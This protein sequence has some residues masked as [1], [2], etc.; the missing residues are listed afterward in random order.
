MKLLIETNELVETSISEAL[1]EGG[2]KNVFI[3]GTFMS[4]DK[5]NRNGRYYPKSVLESEVNR[6]LK[7]NVSKSRAYGELNHPKEPQINL[8]RVSHLITELKVMDNGTVHGKA[9]LVD[10]PMGNIARGLIE[11]GANLGVSTRGM[12]SLKEMKEG[13]KE[14]QNDFKLVTAADIVADPS[15]SDAYVDALMENVNWVRDP[16]SGEWIQEQQEAVHKKSR[17]ELEEAKVYL[18]AQYLEK[19]L[20]TTPDYK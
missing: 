11:G 7:E 18:F 3:E 15:A 5:P 12:G 10:T 16:V 17:K 4:Y 19:L 8:D 2:K 20:K 14:V 13:L 9:K 6:Y 1:E